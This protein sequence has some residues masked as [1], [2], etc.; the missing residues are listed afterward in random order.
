MI[1]VKAID[2]TVILMLQDVPE[3]SLCHREL[4]GD[5]YVKIPFTLA[6]P[7]YLRLGSYVNLP[8]FGRFELIDLYSPKY[9]RE[10]SGYDYTLR[11]DAYYMKF[12]NKKV[13]YMPTSAA[14]ETSFN[15]TATIETHL[16]VIINGMN[17]LGAIDATYRYEGQQYQFQLFNFPADKLAMAKLKQYND[18]DFIS[19][20]NDLAQIFDCEWWFEANVLYFGKCVLSGTEVDF[21]LDVNVEE[22]SSSQSKNEFATR[23]IAFGSDRNLPPDY[24]KDDSA[25]ITHNGVVQKRL[26]LP[27]DSCPHGYVEDES[28]TNENEAVEAVIIDDDI[29]P[30]V[31][32]ETG[33]VEKEMIDVIDPDTQEPTGDQ[34]PI[35]RITD[36]DGFVVTEEMRLVGELHIIFESGDLNGMEFACNPYPADDP[37]GF[38]IIANEDY[39]RRL[40][41]DDLE[42]RTAAQNAA[43]GREAVG[44]K[45]VITGWDSTKIQETH[46]VE[47]AEEELL[48]A[49]QAKLAK[50]K[51]D[52]NTYNC[53]MMSD[54]YEDKMTTD[55]L[56]AYSLGQPV[57]LVNQ[58]Y[59][60]SGRSSRVI[61]Y[62]IKLD[63]MY[64]TPS[65]TVGEAAAYSRSKDI[66]SK[67][68][69]ITVNGVSYQGSGGSGGSGVYIITTTSQTIP[70]DFNVYSAKRSDQQ[71]LRRDR[72]DIAFGR[73]Q[74]KQKDIFENGAQFGSSFVPGL[75]GIGGS[76]DGRGYA[77]FRGLKLWEWLEVPEIRFNKISV[78]IGLRM[79]SVGGGIIETV[80][81]DS[82]GLEIGECTLK[83]EDG[84]VG[85]IEVGDFCMGIWHD[86]SGNSTTNVDD[87]RGLFS[88]KGFKTVYFQ[89]TSVPAYDADGHSNSDRHYFTYIL[90]GEAAGGN[91]IHPF[92]AMHFSTRGNPTLTDRQALYYETTQ[93]TIWLNGVNS[94]EF[95]PSNY[96]EIRGN[97]EGFS[98]PAIDRQGNPYIK[99]FHGYGQVFGNAYVFGQIDQFERVA[100][101][102]FVD[103]SLNGVF[104]PTDT[105]TVTVTVLNGYG[106]DVTSQFQYIR[107]TRDSG[108]AVSDAAWNAL[109][110]NV[111][112]PFQIGYSDLGIDGIRQVLAVFHVVASDAQGETVEQTLSYSS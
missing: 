44:D 85:A 41:D 86:Q 35:F 88:F 74:H 73:I 37:T 65:Y 33:T 83:L 5:H 13:R 9:N 69:A 50:M 87:H 14:S 7:V 96:I 61:G 23:I 39:G 40:P 95:Q 108:D 75:V 27:L 47:D 90:R 80:T 17:A 100:Y 1:Q 36:K 4:M 18:T 98:M 66:Q 63:L 55:N 59:F 84:D 19:A 32:C 12:R 67:L 103:Q 2:N 112:N 28:V 15:L 43:I 54:W 34:V 8:H 105:E 53:K 46:L 6:D 93:Y 92:A 64:D 111:S 25:D 51:I 79:L 76:V 42:P 22:M 99:V 3:G 57:R 30:R 20:L 10:T 52:P 11:L 62:E 81:P 56:V 70:S 49:V 60:A 26:M 101:K 24:R 109:H 107:V 72:A 31:K 94:W 78:N 29:Y 16:G 102:C 97:L 21:E 48:Q 68:D 106:E 91:G 38:E 89:I 71:F 104:A 77:E 45:F 58:T 110:T 82:T